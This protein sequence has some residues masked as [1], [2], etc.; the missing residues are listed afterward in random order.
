MPPTR[1]RMAL[2]SENKVRSI[3]SSRSKTRRPALISVFS[4]RATSVFTL[5]EEMSVE[6]KRF[7]VRLTGYTFTDLPFQCCWETSRGQPGTHAILTNFAGGTLGQNLDQGPLQE[8]ATTFI[9]QV[10]QIYQGAQEAFTRQ[11]VRQH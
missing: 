9:S 10:D 7:D 8:R 1:E 6:E 2:S 3:S 11:A 4:V 5:L